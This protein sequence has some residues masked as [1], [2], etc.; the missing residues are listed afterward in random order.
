VLEARRAGLIDEFIVANPCRP[1]ARPRLAWHAAGRLAAAAPLAQATVHTTLDAGLQARLEDFA[2]DAAR[3][4][5]PESTVA[6]VVVD[7]KTRGVLAS[8]GSGGL[9]RPGGWVDMTRALRSP[10]S[11]LKPFVYAMAF[12]QG[13]ARTLVQDAAMRFGDYQPKLRPCSTAR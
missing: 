6:I 7:L 9:D 10:G 8:V 11:A 3:A 5:G 2:R 13:I 12:D 4:Q 1:R